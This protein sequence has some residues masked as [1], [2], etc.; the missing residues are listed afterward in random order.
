MVL[1]LQIR[2]L[3]AWAVVHKTI[4]KWKKIQKK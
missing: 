4:K 1:N 3:N 2:I